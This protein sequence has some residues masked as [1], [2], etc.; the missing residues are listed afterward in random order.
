MSARRDDFTRRVRTTVTGAARLRPV[1]RSVSAKPG[2]WITSDHWE[3][4]LVALAPVGSY[5]GTCTPADSA[6]VAGPVTRVAVLWHWVGSPAPSARTAGMGVAAAGA[7]QEEV[8]LRIL[9][10]EH[11]RLCGHG[12]GLVRLWGG[13]RRNGGGPLAARS[14]IFVVTVAPA[15]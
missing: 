1:G 15:Y 4:C 5:V 12:G 13:G 7:G 14:A 10:G 9:R 8:L 11:D 3:G 2:A 6:S